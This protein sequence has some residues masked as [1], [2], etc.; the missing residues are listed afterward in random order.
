MPSMG[1][2]PVVMAAIDKRGLLSAAPF[3][4]MP[5]TVLVTGFTLCFSTPLACAIFPQQVR[6]LE[7]PSALRLRA[8]E[9]TPRLKLTL[10]GAGLDQRLAARA[11]AAGQG[12]CPAPACAA[13]CAARRGCNPTAQHA[14][15]SRSRNCAPQRR[16]CTTTRAFERVAGPR[17]PRCPCS[18]WMREE[19]E[20]RSE[21]QAWRSFPQRECCF[22]CRS[23]L[24]APRP[25]TSA[26][27]CSAW[28]AAPRRPTLRNLGHVWRPATVPRIMWEISGDAAHEENPPV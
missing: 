23:A 18:R 19:R 17:W 3:L 16:S 25:G 13:P 26:A 2:T 4:T 27:S 9:R 5:V 6:R 15:P 11:G 8:L 28:V 24:H 20:S 12:A 10:P 14:G 7:R 22:V 1:F 21:G